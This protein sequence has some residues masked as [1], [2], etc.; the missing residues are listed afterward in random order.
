MHDGVMEGKRGRERK[1]GGT[2]IMRE[3]EERRC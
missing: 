1:G 3:K 2:L